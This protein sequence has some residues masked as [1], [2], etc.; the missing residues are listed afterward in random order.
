MRGI[1]LDMFRRSLTVLAKRT[2]RV[3]VRDPRIAKQRKATGLVESSGASIQQLQEPSAVVPSQQPASPS[4]PPAAL[5]FEPS[6][7]NQQ[8]VGSTIGSYVLAG[9]GVGLGMILVRVVLGF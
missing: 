7:Q 8:S 9:F 2:D 3:I 6:A 5:P 1:E 4:A